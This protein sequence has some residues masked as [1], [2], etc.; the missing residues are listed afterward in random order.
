MRNASLLPDKK[1][2]IKP[3]GD[4]HA[5]A[6][7]CDA[8]LLSSASFILSFN[9]PR[10]LAPDTESCSVQAWSGMLAKRCLF[11]SIYSNGVT[12][13]SPART[14]AALLSSC[15]IPI[16][17]I[18]KHGRFF[19]IDDAIMIKYVTQNAWM[20]VIIDNDNNFF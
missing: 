16:E 11:W 9:T 3:T 13:T 6:L 2:P 12:G 1:R 4:H 18:K 17:I 8:L 7:Y 14:V 19:L 15:D 20:V 5:C 10:K